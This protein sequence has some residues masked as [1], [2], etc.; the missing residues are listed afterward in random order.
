MIEYNNQE[1]INTIIINNVALV[2][3]YYAKWC[4]PCKS[5]SQ[6]LLDLKND[7]GN[8]VK[9]VAVNV[10][11]FPIIALEHN[12]RAVPTLQY[13]KNGALYLKQSGFRTKDQ[14]QKNIEALI[15]VPTIEEK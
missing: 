8:T 13:Y 2:I 4:M 10:D 6:T 7:F 9:F 12:V 14:L 3:L 11:D 15:N 5:I 1:T